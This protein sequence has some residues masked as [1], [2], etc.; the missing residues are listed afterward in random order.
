MSTYTLD[1]SMSSWRIHTSRGGGIENRQRSHTFLGIHWFKIWWRM[2]CTVFMVFLTIDISTKKLLLKVL[3]E[4]KFFSPF[5]LW[6]LWCYLSS[7]YSLLRDQGLGHKTKIRNFWLY[8]THSIPTILHS[9]DST[10]LQLYDNNIF[11]KIA[12]PLICWNH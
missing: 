7:N 12:L 10:V 9:W 2:L 5:G 11:L 4:G 8:N 3:F 1:W 6:S